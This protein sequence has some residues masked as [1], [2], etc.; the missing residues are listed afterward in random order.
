[1]TQ[2]NGKKSLLYANDVCLYR[3]PNGDGIYYDTKNK[4]FFEYTKFPDRELFTS[5]SYNEAKEKLR[6]L[7]PFLT[8][9][10]KDVLQ[11]LWSDF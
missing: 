7:K 8:K 10:A 3:Y 4:Y 9:D 11:K 5:L 2:T 6:A 1:M